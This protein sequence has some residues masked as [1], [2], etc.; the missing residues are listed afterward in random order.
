MINGGYYCDTGAW[1][2]VDEPPAKLPAAA[3]D[4]RWA[5]DNDRQSEVDDLFA[6]WESDQLELLSLPDLGM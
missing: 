3:A 6:Q 1:D 4:N 5:N 2:R